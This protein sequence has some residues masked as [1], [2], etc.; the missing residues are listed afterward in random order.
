MPTA[1]LAT[2]QLARSPGN[3]TRSAAFTAL[4]VAGVAA[5]RPILELVVASEVHISQAGQRRPW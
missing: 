4:L 1:A 2:P 3:L 5:A